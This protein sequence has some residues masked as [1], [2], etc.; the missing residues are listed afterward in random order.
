MFLVCLFSAMAAP[1]ADATSIFYLAAPMLVLF[2]TVLGLCLLN[3]RRRERRA[4]KLAAQIEATA[5]QGTPGSE[6]EN[7]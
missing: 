5:D 7:L 3:D 6:M 1:G 4:V 2:F